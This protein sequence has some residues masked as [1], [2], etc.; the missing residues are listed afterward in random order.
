MFSSDLRHFPLCAEFLTVFFLRYCRTVVDFVATDAGWLLK[1]ATLPV[2][3]LK[4]ILAKPKAKVS[5]ADM[6]QAVKSGVEEKFIRKVSGLR[7]D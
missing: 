1:P 5:I 3:V 7:K 6:K 2:H 4:G